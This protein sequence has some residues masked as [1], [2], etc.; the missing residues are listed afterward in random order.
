MRNFYTAVL[1]LDLSKQVIFK[2]GIDKVRSLRSLILRDEDA[3]DIRMLLP[4][5]YNLE[6]RIDRLSLLTTWITYALYMLFTQ[7][8]SVL[9]TEITSSVQHD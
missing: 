9:F 6:I 2:F 1:F 3:S 4:L 7:S 8:I 5:S